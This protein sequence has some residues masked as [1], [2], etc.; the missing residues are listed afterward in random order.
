M[1]NYVSKYSALVGN[2]MNRIIF[3]CLGSFTNLRKA[4]VSFLMSVH[5]SV[6]PSFHLSTYNNSASSERILIKFY[7]WAFFENLSKKIQVSLKSE[8]NNGYLLYLNTFFTHMTISR[9]IL[10][11]TRNVLDKSCREK[12]NTFC[13]VQRFF[14]EFR[15]FYDIMSKNMVQPDWQQVT[16]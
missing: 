6:R 7:A 10:P 13:S 5:L 16:I 8:M 3:S 14:S 15:V 4:A 9:W 11:G 12:E 2:Y 1:C